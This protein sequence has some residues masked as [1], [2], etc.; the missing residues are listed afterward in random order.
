MKAFQFWQHYS[1]KQKIA[2]ILLCLFFFLTSNFIGIRVGYCSSSPCGDE[3]ALSNSENDHYGELYTNVFL[4]PTAVLVPVALNIAGYETN[5]EYFITPS[6]I[7][8]IVF[9]FF[10]GVYQQIKFDDKAEQLVS[11]IPQDRVVDNDRSR[12]L[13]GYIL[14]QSILL[15]SLPVWILLSFLMIKFWTKNTIA[16]IVITLLIL[17]MALNSLSTKLVAFIGGPSTAQ[18]WEVLFRSIV[19]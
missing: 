1:K 9:A 10:P 7:G 4:A 3:E 15:F 16:K 13:F 6:F 8:G 14:I 12:M 17:W 19:R 11:T 2:F 5:T 18:I